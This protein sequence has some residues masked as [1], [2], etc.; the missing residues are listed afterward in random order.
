MSH[1]GGGKLRAWLIEIRKIK[2]MTQLEVANKA[3]IS[4]SYYSDI[5]RGRRD[6]GG[7]TAKRISDVLGFDMELF[8]EDER[9]KMRHLSA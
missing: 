2:N 7:K 8:F 5:E 1:N 4:R 9:R 6:P 3:K